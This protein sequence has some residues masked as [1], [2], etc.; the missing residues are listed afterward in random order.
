[1]GCIHNGSIL[2]GFS[3]VQLAEGVAAGLKKDSQLD[4]TIAQ[5]AETLPADGG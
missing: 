1:L 2:M 5:V 4:V 3:S